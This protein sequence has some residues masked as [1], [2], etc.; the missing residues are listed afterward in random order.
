M[1]QFAKLL[2]IKNN[3]KIIKIT[4]LEKNHGTDNEITERVLFWNWVIW[5]MY[6]NQYL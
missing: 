1:I 4:T 6:L 5:W 3:Y 2:Y